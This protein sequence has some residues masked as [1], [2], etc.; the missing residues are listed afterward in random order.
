MEI[1]RF[2]MILWKWRWL[3]SGTLITLFVSTAIF[4]YAQIPV[5]ETDVRLIVS[6][7]SIFM[8]DLNNLRSAVTALSAPVVANTYAEIS[9]SPNVI[10]KAWKQLSIDPKSGYVVNSTVLQETTI[11]IINVS[12]PNPEIVQKLA[13]AVADETLKYIEGLI[14]VYDLALLDPASLPGSPTSPNYYF[15]LVLGFAVGI[16]A[17]VLF[18]IMA[19]YLTVSSSEDIG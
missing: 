2:L 15:N 1:K 12:G 16:L 11:L 18:A 13:A 3:F 7:S 6:P 14:T 5:Y 10:E 9:Q 17:G 8:T 4:T 19:E